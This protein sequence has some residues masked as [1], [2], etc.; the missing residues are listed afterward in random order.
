M[1]QHHGDWMALGSADEQRP[2]AAGTVEAWSRASDNPMGVGMAKERASA[3]V[4]LCTYLRSWNCSIGP[5]LSTVP[6]ITGGVRSEFGTG[7]N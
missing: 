2:K 5:N 1:L 6:A 7:L 4:S 3:G